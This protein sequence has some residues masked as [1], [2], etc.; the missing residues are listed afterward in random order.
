MRYFHLHGAMACFREQ[1]TQRVSSSIRDIV[2]NANTDL[3][4]T[5]KLLNRIIEVG[6][7]LGELSVATTVLK[8][9][10]PDV[11]SR[12]GHGVEESQ[13]VL[14]HYV[15]ACI[16]VLQSSRDRQVDEAFRRQ[17]SEMEA[18]FDNASRHE[19]VAKKALFLAYE[20]SDRPDVVRRRLDRLV[21]TL[22][23]V[24]HSLHGYEL[25]LP[26][27]CVPIVRE[28]AGAFDE[29]ISDA[30][31]IANADSWYF[32]SI[33][34]TGPSG[35]DADGRMKQGV[36]GG[37]LRVAEAVSNSKILYAASIGM[38]GLNIDK[39][40][41]A[42][43]TSDFGYFIERY[44]EARFFDKLE[45]GSFRPVV[46]ALEEV[47]IYHLASRHALFDKGVENALR[48]QMRLGHDAS[49]VRDEAMN[50]RLLVDEAKRNH[51]LP[52][53]RHSRRTVY[54]RTFR[55]VECKGLSAVGDDS[56]FQ[57]V[58]KG[59]LG[60]YRADDPQ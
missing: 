45:G 26:D 19:A 42:S 53:S 17:H 56:L 31:R 18:L 38:M 28:M 51:A 14:E 54:D 23:L 13:S 4:S 8:S 7:T 15:G 24:Q 40:L 5:S 9:D 21:G 10:A 55:N 46:S 39:R 3:P 27:D 43:L 60:S 20:A 36:A 49:W 30:V 11:W 52:A 57:G 34:S 47:L 29:V 33:Q 48:L 32:S 16:A 59:L 50:A 12:F 37:L 6:N 41:A 25:Y 44:A 2:Q 1:Y 22:G 35:E 58:N